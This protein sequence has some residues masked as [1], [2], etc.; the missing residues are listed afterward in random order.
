MG[1]HC[2]MEIK[3]VGLLPSLSGP[4]GGTATSALNDWLAGMVRRLHV[5]FDK[6]HVGLFELCVID[7]LLAV[8]S[9]SPPPLF[10]GFCLVLVQ[11]SFVALVLHRAV[12]RRVLDPSSIGDLGAALL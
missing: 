11:A 1:S 8:G 9:T 3:L 10:R 4:T 12:H 2:L 7:G 6:V 5:A